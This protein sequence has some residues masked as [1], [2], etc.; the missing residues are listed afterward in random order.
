MNDKIHFHN[1]NLTHRV[2]VAAIV[3]RHRKILL[4]HRTTSPRI[5]APPGGHLYVREDPLVGLSREV[6]EEC[7]IAVEPVKPI[8]LWIGEHK[9]ASLLALPIVCKY[10]SGEVKISEE[11][12][13]FKWIDPT[14]FKIQLFQINNTS[15]FGSLDDYLYAVWL[16]EQLNIEKKPYE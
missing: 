15:V 9:G 14:D 4:L 12:S 10:V 1:S 16:L 6:W 2:A 3:V 5:W 13:D 7:R 8:A 11:H